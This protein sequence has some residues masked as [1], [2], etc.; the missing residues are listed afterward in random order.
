MI[1]IRV[2]SEGNPHFILGVLPSDVGYVYPG[3]LKVMVGII[4]GLTKDPAGLVNLKLQWLEL[5]SGC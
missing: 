3:I 4:F 1:F 2:D 5:F